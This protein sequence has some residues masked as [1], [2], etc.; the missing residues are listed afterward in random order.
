MQRSLVFAG[1]NLR[2]RALRLGPPVVVEERD[3]VV[4]LRV[5]AM[6]A[7]QIHLGELDRRDLARAHQL[8]EMTDRPERDVLEIRRTLHRRRGAQAKRQL[9]PIH[10]DAR[11]DRA[12]VKRRRHV[13]RDVDGSQL[14]VAREILIGGVDHAL[15]VGLGELEAGQLHRVR[16]HRRGDL[17]RAGVLH[18]RPQ[19]AGRQRPAKA[20]AR[21]V[22]EE[23]SP[24]FIQVRHAA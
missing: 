21:E 15:Q 19:N 24:R 2:V 3:H 14:L 5:V 18:P 13:V 22:R 6:E 10:L 12:E 11:H 4:Q 8:R 20:H 17:L 9:R 7:R 23:A 16:H 1:G